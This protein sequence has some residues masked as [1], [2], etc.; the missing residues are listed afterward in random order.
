MKLGFLTEYD[1]SAAV[2]A[3]SHGF[4]CLEVIAPPGSALAMGTL[5]GT[6]PC[7]PL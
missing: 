5:K 6:T 2:F 3:G 7:S 4:G 1:E